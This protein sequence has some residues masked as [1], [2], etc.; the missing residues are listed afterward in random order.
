MLA[1]HTRPGSRLTAAG[2]R[3]LTDLAGQAG[4]ILRN[5]KLI[6]EL[7]TSRERLVTARDAERRRLE[8][9]IRVRVERRLASVAAALD[10]QRTGAQTAEER[11]VVAELQKE[12]ASARSQLQDLARGVYPPLLADQ[13]LVAALHAHTRTLAL[14][15]NIVA[16]GLG[17]LAQDVEAAA[18]FCCL[19][20]LQNVVKYARAQRVV[21]TLSQSVDRLQFGVDDDGVGF[22]VAS[23]RRGA[24]LQNMADRAEALGGFVEV[25]SSPGIGTRVSGWLPSS[26]VERAP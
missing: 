19:E 15:V 18:Y 24:G 3:L 11:W 17:Q 21:L 16:G 13:G 26:P 8:H 23:T 1:V 9:D 7:R 12:C 5:V 4:L 22:D 14:R 20:A 10:D 2:A 25:R 6:E